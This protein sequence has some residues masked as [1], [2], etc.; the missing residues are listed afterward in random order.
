MWERVLQE[1]LPVMGRA[2]PPGSRIWD[3][4]TGTYSILLPLPGVGLEDHRSGCPARCPAGGQGKRPALP[5]APCTEFHC[6]PP[7]ESRQHQE[8]Y[9]AVFIKTVLYQAA[10]LDDYGEWLDWIARRLKPGGILINFETGRSNRM[11]RMYRK[12]RRREYTDLHLY[13]PAVEALYDQRFDIIARRYYGG[14]SQFAAPW[15]ALYRLAARLE[16]TVRSRDAD[17]CFVV[18]IIGH[19]RER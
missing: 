7:E 16:E 10:N 5:L 3:W 18:S 1:A 19:K 2:A 12:V 17:N 14:W 15:P 9:D 4:V 13:T 6:I 11:V 8:V